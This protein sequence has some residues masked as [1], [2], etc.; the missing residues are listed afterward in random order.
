MRLLAKEMWF[1]GSHWMTGREKGSTIILD[2]LPMICN[3]PSL[4]SCLFYGVD[5]S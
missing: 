2:S 3:V 4:P 5:F 1:P